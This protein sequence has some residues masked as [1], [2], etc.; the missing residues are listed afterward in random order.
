LHG[1]VVAPAAGTTLHGMGAKYRSWCLCN[2]DFLACVSSNAGKLKKG[3]GE[4]VQHGG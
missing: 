4:K 3:D 2:S 1:D